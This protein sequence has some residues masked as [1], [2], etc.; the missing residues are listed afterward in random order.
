MNNAFLVG[1]IFNN[2]GING[3]KNNGALAAMVTRI[4]IMPALSPKSSIRKENKG[5]KSPKPIE[6]I[7]PE[8]KARPMVI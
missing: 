3:V 4:P 6:D 7:K 8:L 2:L 5:A 1:T